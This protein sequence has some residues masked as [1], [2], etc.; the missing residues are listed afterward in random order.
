MSEFAIIIFISIICGQYIWNT[1]FE[2]AVLLMHHFVSDVEELNN[3][4]DVYSIIACWR[5]MNCIMWKC[6]YNNVN[7]EFPSEDGW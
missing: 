7:V 2:I 5:V 1:K 4:K 3:V 6:T